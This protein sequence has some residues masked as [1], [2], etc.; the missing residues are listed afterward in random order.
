[1]GGGGRRHHF[2]VWSPVARIE[3]FRNSVG[4][5]DHDEKRKL[6]SRVAHWKNAGAAPIHLGRLAG[7]KVEREEYLHGGGRAQ[8]GQ[9]MVASSCIL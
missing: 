6:A 3:R 5:E 9:V 7:S 4:K 8:R 2:E 1:M